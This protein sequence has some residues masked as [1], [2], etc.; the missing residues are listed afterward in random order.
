MLVVALSLFSVVASASSNL[1]N[2]VMAVSQSMSAFYMYS[3][4]EGDTRYKTEYEKYFNTAEGYL[5]Q[6]QKEDAVTAS[7]LNSQWNRLRPEL[8]FE[9]VDGAGFII[10]VTVRNEFRSYLNKA[11]SKLTETLGVEMDFN[12]ELFHMG[13]SVEVMS[14][15]FFDISSALYGTMSIAN[16]DGVIDPVNMAKHL[17]ERLAQASKRDI[18][19]SIK[20]ELRQVQTKWEFIEDSVV[21]YRDEAAYL[22][23]YFNK[24][25]ITKILNKTQEVLAKA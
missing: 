2:H 21:N 15:R 22:L 12:K 6:Y 19:E 17:N 4:S 9:Y 3:L 23:V 1:S 13:L 10:P 20:R 11:Y 24:S 8:K 5:G 18:P 7:E 14:A 25:K 16:K